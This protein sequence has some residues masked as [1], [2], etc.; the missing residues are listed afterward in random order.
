MRLFTSLLV[1][2]LISVAAGARENH[3][4]HNDGKATGTVVGGILG[5]VAGA[6]LG[7]GKAA[8]IIIGGV[9]GGVA[10]RVV[11]D[12]ADDQR[13]FDECGTDSESFQRDVQRQE[14]RDDDRYARD[15][16]R[17]SEIE[18][19][20]EM[21]RRGRGYP[22]RSYPAPGYPSRSYPAP[23]PRLMDYQCQSDRYGQFVLVFLPTNRIVQNWGR[24]LYDC[25]DAERQA[26]RGF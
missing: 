8:P 9:A 20:R 16:R 24:D 10:G 26:N 22:G 21:S 11:G 7:H 18:Y 2:T 19:D 14:R 6:L 1:L 17:A 12:G 15:S 23:R 3:C 4:D 5:G 25:Q 13:D